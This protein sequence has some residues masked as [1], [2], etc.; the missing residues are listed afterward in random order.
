MATPIFINH[1][2]FSKLVGSGHASVYKQYCFPKHKS[3]KTGKIQ[4]GLEKINAISRDL[5]IM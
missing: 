4:A 5:K 3:D 2:Y 1:C